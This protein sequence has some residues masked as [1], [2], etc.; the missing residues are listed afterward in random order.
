MEII[1][2]RTGSFDARL[3]VEFKELVYGTLENR[4]IDEGLF[5]EDGMCIST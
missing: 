2:W 1:I 5:V 4:N 3:H